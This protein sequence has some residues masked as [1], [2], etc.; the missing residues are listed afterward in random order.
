[1]KKA[2]TTD[3]FELAVYKRG[4][5]NAQRLMLCLPGR[6][7]TKDYPHMR[8]HV[9]YFAQR[10]Y[11]ALSFDPPGTWESPGDITLYTMS[12]YLKAINEL[13][14]YFG[15][16]PTVLLGHSRGGTMAMYAGS[17]SPHVTHIIAIM[18]HVG[19]STLTEETKRAGVYISKRDTPEGYEVPE[20]EFRLPLS[21]FEDA[22]THDVMST[23]RECSLPKLL[24]YGTEDTLVSKE[25]VVK[26]FEEVSPPK[27]MYELRCE[28]D[29]RR[30]E[31]VIAEVNHEVERFLT[32]H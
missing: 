28:H 11:L 6:L 27:E 1:M 10:G 31:A 20:V 18:S 32:T 22:R 8:G 24:M 13:I 23:F 14:A 21:Y 26:V 9:D 3:T 2:V 29:Y 15:N 25:D 30:H 19:E 4:D 12:N 7:D 16:R 5:E 17:T